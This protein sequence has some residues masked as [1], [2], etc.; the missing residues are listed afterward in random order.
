MTTQEKEICKLT[1]HDCAMLCV[2]GALLLSTVLGL[3]F[4]VPKWSAWKQGVKGSGELQKAESSRRIIVEQARAE[5]DAAE[6]QAEAIAIVGEAAQKY[7]EYREQQFMIAFGNAV[8]QGD[9]KLI[10]VPTEA[11]VPILVSPDREP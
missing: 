2:L 11:N 10:F 3:M 6:L 9:V 4:G 7:P 8:E 1:G 5:R